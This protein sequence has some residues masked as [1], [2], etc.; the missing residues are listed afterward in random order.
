MNTKAFSLS[1][2]GLVSIFANAPAIPQ[3]EGGGCQCA[4]TFSIVSSGCDG[5]GFQFTGGSATPTPCNANCVRV[6][7]NQCSLSG[8]ATEF[9][10]LPGGGQGVVTNEDSVS[11]HAGCTNSNQ[12]TMPCFG[13][14]SGSHVVTLNCG[15]CH[16]P[17][18]G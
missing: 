3:T 5:Y 16:P 4:A 11:L 7:G 14:G 17:G 6:T 18:S 10:L 2:L 13:G 15:A 8:T 1:L 9:S 12:F